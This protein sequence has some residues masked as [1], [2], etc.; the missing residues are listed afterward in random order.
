MILSYFHCTQNEKS[1]QA[2]ELFI[3]HMNIIF[4]LVCLETTYCGGAYLSPAERLCPHQR[5]REY[6]P[7]EGSISVRYKGSLMPSGTPLTKWQV[8][9]KI[10]IC[11]S[12]S[13]F[14]CSQ[15]SAYCLAE[16]L[17]LHYNFFWTALMPHRQFFS[18][19]TSQLF[20][21]WSHNYGWSNCTVLYRHKNDKMIAELLYLF[22]ADFMILI[23]TLTAIIRRR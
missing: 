8:V 11:H 18:S 9:S 21:H 4:L 12:L 7:G 15:H 1:E 22:I 10:D 23:L 5:G 16:R 17:Q 20:V 2:I 14:L 13:F 19:I 3:F 6:S